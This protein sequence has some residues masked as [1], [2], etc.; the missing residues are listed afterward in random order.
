VT[1][2]GV[3]AER[4]DR[5]VQV[6]WKTADE[7]DLDGYTVMHSLNGVNWTDIGN[8]SPKGG[9]ENQYDHLH[10]Q[11]PTG[12]NYYRIRAR[13]LTGELKYSKVVLVNVDDK[14]LLSIYP[15]PAQGGQKGMLRLT[16]P[17]VIHIWRADGR[18]VSTAFYPAGTHTLNIKGLTPGIYL[19]GD[20]EHS[21]NWI[22]Q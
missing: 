3:A 5:D 12:K 8:A 20:G 4:K 18:L 14:G 19:I 7:S 21:I 22:I 2:L 6:T 16:K 1:W 17:G 10:L 15:N 13:E 11:P 9:I